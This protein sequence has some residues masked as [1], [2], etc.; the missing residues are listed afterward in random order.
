MPLSRERMVFL[1]LL[2]PFDVTFICYQVFANPAK[3]NP[4]L[5]AT[6]YVVGG[7]GRA[8]G[9]GKNRG[10]MGS[11]HASDSAAPGAAAAALVRVEISIPFF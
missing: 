3:R 1:L 5:A 11:S 9:E 7:G 8:S 10:Y 4:Y 2:I 6:S